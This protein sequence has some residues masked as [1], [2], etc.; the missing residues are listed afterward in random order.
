M[1]ISSD[2]KSGPEQRREQ[3]NYAV[4]IVNVRAIDD[5]DNYTVDAITADANNSGVTLLTNRP[6]TIGTKIEIRVAGELAA[7]GEI[8]N[9]REDENG[10]TRMGVRLIE[11]NDNWQLLL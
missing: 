9:L 10:L 6:T 1:V 4:V 2:P 11:K 7:T 5:K 3:R 8:V